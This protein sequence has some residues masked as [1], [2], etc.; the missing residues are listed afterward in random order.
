M[1]IIKTSTGFEWDVDDAHKDDQELVDLCL[2]IDESPQRYPKLLTHILGADG[3]K[4]LYEHVRGEDGIV[5]ASM[6]LKEME[7]IIHAMKKVPEIKN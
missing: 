5:K 6:V 3:R 4:A 2:E 1:M 7:D